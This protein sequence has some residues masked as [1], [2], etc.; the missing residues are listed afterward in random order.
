MMGL[1]G[2]IA[3]QVLMG[4][5]VVESELAKILIDVYIIRGSENWSWLV[6]GTLKKS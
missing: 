1:C 4:W 3:E 5:G 6:S 2:F